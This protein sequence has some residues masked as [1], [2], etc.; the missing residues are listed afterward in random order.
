MCVYCQDELDDAD[1]M[2][3]IGLNKI[4][5]RKVRA[6]LKASADETSKKSRNRTKSGKTTTSSSASIGGPFSS[7]STLEEVDSANKLLPLPNVWARSLAARSSDDP[8]LPESMHPS[9]REKAKKKGATR[10]IES[11]STTETATENDENEDPLAIT[12]ASDKVAVHINSSFESARSVLPPPPR[13]R[14][15]SRSGWSEQRLGQRIDAPLDCVLAVAR[16]IALAEASGN[17]SSG[18]SSG[19]KAATHRREKDSSRVK[20]GAS[21][22]AGSLLEDRAG[23]FGAVQ[24]AVRKLRTCWVNAGEAAALGLELRRLQKVLPS[25]ASLACCATSAAQAILLE[26]TLQLLA[27]NDAGSGSSSSSSQPVLAAVPI[28]VIPRDMAALGVSPDVLLVSFTHTAP[29]QS[30]GGQSRRGGG[31][32]RTGGSSRAAVA[33]SVEAVSGHFTCSSTVAIYVHIR[34]L[35]GQ[36]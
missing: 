24:H 14:V 34:L 25:T 29:S 21:P 7:S 18:R 35:N 28:R 3:E 2:A 16:A 15:T 9:G 17:G 5:C 30:S 27:A 11:R 31:G 33:R 4:Q 19:G 26:A 36:T 22:L 32:G 20:G 13:V 12:T 23:A 1:L 8:L 10:A 6:M